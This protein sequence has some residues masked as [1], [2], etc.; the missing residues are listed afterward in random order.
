MELLYALIGLAGGMIG[1]A[2]FAVKRVQQGASPTL[3]SIVTPNVGG[4]GGPKPVK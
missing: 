3:R 1:G 4:G 2:A